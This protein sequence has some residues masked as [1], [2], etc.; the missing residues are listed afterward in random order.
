[1]HSITRGKAVSGLCRKSAQASG[2]HT[3]SRCVLACG[4]DNLA[5]YTPFRPLVLRVVFHGQLQLFS[6]VKGQVLPII[7]RPY[8]NNN[9]LNKLIT[10]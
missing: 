9:D 6:S 2:L 7:N 10:I 3:A 5:V 8:K 4:V 1:M